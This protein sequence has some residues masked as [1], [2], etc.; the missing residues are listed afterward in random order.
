MRPL[1][2]NIVSQVWGAGRSGIGGELFLRFYRR[3]P[4]VGGVCNFLGSVSSQQKY[5]V[6]DGP[7]LQPWDG[8]EFQLRVTAQFYL[9]IKENT[10]SRCE[11]MP[12]Q[13]M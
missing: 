5:E 1:R 12:T 2:T 10:S 6:M 9:E 13:K 8:P 3:P 7:A 4:T 11:G